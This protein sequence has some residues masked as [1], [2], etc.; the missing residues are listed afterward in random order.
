MSG[1][2]VKPAQFHKVQGN[3]QLESTLGHAETVDAIIK[4]NEAGY[5]PD[6]IH[7]RSRIDD[8]MMTGET[9]TDDLESLESDPRVE[10]VSVSRRLRVIE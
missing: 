8:F 7:L 9:S 6:V 2:K 5:V 3:V 10:S 1:F 4:V